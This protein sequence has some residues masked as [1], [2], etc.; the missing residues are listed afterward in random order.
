[1]ANLAAATGV[2]YSGDNCI[3]LGDT[4]LDIEGAHA[5]GAR[6][7]GVATG[8]FSVDELTASGAD[9]ALADLSDTAG[10]LRILLG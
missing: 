6:A 8:R 5:A 3:V 4:P 2:V 7:I 1:M 9:W 10:V